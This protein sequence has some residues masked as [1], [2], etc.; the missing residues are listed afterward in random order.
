MEENSIVLN[1]KLAQ[2]FIEY[3][4]DRNAQGRVERF[5]HVG[6]YL[7]FPMVG[8]SSELQRLADSMLRI[9]NPN[10][11]Y[12]HSKTKGFLHLLIQDYVT[13]YLIPD[14]QVNLMRILKRLRNE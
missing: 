9:T 7:Q 14:M 2:N 5:I 6:D 13:S 12:P 11:F 3:M 1:L 4:E 10:Q 8:K